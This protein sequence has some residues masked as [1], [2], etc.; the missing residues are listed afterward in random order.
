MSNTNCQKFKGEIENYLG[1][2]IHNIESKVD[3]TFLI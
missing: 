2:G 1:N 3:A